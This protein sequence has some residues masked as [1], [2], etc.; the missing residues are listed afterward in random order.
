MDEDK[1]EGQRQGKTKTW[2]EGGCGM[3]MDE[4]MEGGQGTPMT[5][6]EGDRGKTARTKSDDD[7]DG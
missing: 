1:D 6:E 5:Q 4:A 2:E 7:K 3:R